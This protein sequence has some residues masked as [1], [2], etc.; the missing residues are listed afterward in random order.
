MSKGL[1]GWLQAV[2]LYQAAKSV[3]RGLAHLSPA[4]QHQQRAMLEFYRAFVRP[5]DLCFDVGANLGD[6]TDIFLRLGAR[7][8]AV[9]PQP[10]CADRLR[11]RFKGN[12]RVSIVAKALGAAGGEA[13][14]QLSS[15]DTISSLSSEWIDKVRASG[16]FAQYQWQ[17]RI[18]VPMTTL[19]ELIR[20]FGRPAFC[21][22]DVEGY[23]DQVLRGLSQNLPCLSFE[24]TPEYLEPA[25]KSVQHLDRLG[26]ARFNYSEAETMRLAMEEWVPADK[27]RK[28]LTELPDK[29]IFGDV[30][31]K[32]ET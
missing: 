2:G 15:A 7:V 32:S 17:G 1:L 25:L 30:Y 4:W 12:S 10:L 8:V 20:E 22:I 19:D 14:M 23:E 31:V 5:G 16:R 27:M 26:R 6:R 21:K 24:F 13:D 29:S 11:Q 9:D 18:K 28:L 3:H